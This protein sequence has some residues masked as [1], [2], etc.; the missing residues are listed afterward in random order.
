M[1][2]NITMTTTSLAAAFLDQIGLPQASGKRV[3]E[4]DRELVDALASGDL[5]ANGCADLVLEAAD[6]IADLDP[7]RFDW[8]GWDDDDD[9]PG[10]DDVFDFESLGWGRE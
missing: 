7:P 2:V 1:N 8:R 6:L 10:D 5:D 9:D 4:I 3:I